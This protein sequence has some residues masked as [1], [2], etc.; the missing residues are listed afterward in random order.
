MRVARKV[1]GKRNRGGEHEARPFDATMRGLALE[2]G[3]HR[4]IAGREP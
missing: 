2:I 1:F 3:A 4:R